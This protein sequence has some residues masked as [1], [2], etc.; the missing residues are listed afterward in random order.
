MKL[1]LVRSFALILVLTIVAFCQPQGDREGS[2]PCQEVVT[3]MVPGLHA[4]SAPEKLAHVEVRRCASLG[5]AMQVVAWKG[6]AGSPSVVLD[7]ARFS[8]G[9]LLMAGNVFA[10]VF[11]GSYDSVVVVRYTHGEPKVVF[12][13]STHAEIWLA[14][15]PTGLQ[16]TRDYGHGKKDVKTFPVNESELAASS[17]SSAPRK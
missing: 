3:D 2:R 6:G 4:R 10:M 13:D 16:V 7:I 12:T 9:P 15:T 8:F 14:T 11:P 17:H 5:N 1:Q